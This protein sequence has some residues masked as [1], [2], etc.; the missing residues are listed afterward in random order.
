MKRI[1]YADGSYID[2]S[3]QSAWEYENDPDWVRTEDL[4][5]RWSALTFFGLRPE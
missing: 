2:V 4:P 5:S 3:A 1:W